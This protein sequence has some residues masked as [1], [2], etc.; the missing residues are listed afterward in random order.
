VVK[1]VKVRFDT[2]GNERQKQTAGYWL[3]KTTTDIVYGG[4]K[5][6]LTAGTLVRTMVGLKPIEKV[7]PGN[8]VLTINEQT[9]S[10]E[11][12]VVL[13]Q[14]RYETK[15]ENEYHKIITFVTHTGESLSLT[16]NHEIYINGSWV[17][18]GEFARR[19]LEVYKWD[20][21]E[22]YDLFKGS[23]IELWTD[24]S[25]Y[26]ESYYKQEGVRDSLPISQER[27]VVNSDTPISCLSFHRQS[28]EQTDGK[29]YRF[30]SAQQLYRESGMGD[31]K[32]E[33][34]SLER[35]SET[36]IWRQEGDKKQQDYSNRGAG[37]RNSG[38]IQEKNSDKGDIRQR[39]RSKSCNHKGYNSTQELDASLITEIRF[40]LLQGAVYDLHVARNHNYCITDQ[41]YIVHNSGKS[42][43]GVS[44]IFG[45]AFIYPGTRY[46]IARKT[47]ADLR[48]HTIPSIHEVFNIW[49]IDESM[50]KFNGQDNYFTLHNGSVVLLL[51]A[52]PKPS[53]P[54]YARFGSM[55]ITR[56]WIEEA[57]EF[58][59]GAKNNLAAA[60]GRWKNN[61]YSLKGKLLQTCNPA[62]NY[63][64]RDYYRPNKEGTLPDYRKFVQALPTDNKMLPDG[65]LE[66]LN[67]ILT[68][69][70]KERLLYGNWEYDDDPTVLIDY[71]NILNLFENRHV[72]PTGQR[73]ITGDIARYG[74]D[75]T[76]LMVWDGF[77]VVEMIEIKKSGLDV[78]EQRIRRLANKYEVPVSQI[79]IDEDGVGGGV[80]DQLR[81]RG[82][83]NN[84]RPLVTPSVRGQ[85]TTVENFMNLK[86]QCYFKLAEK[87]NK[88]EMH[89]AADINED[90]KK[91]LIEDLEQVK[92]AHMDNDTKKAVLGKDEVK[93]LIGRSPDFSDALMMRMYFTLQQKRIWYVAE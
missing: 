50:Y 80:V 74:R 61:V 46:F 75:S 63:L 29:P 43:L 22:I 93:K 26:F 38:A 40:E 72:K 12:N 16:P 14:K 28:E 1:S 60:V 89:F 79:L 35:Q 76:V 45:D 57:G 92:Q 34:V 21:E 6:C 51:D 8:V 20:R 87:I 73:Y 49:G 3:D 41:N 9:G 88:F 54:T 4:S 84:S 13:E 66:N 2:H 44:L 7:S 86:S 91:R 85:D 69:N 25:K 5:G 39:I 15:K 24:E 11:W 59:E 48:K 58:E 18:S 31:S 70:E 17:A 77:V 42:F 82:F 62:K 90:Q 78:V 83:V 27:K 56:G 52:A 81:C 23:S 36:V 67:R 68:T 10:E 71:N 33:C 64:Y 32:R 30:R 47:G 65:Y 19:I 53:D 55:Q 37:K